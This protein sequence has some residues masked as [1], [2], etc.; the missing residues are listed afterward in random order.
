VFLKPTKLSSA[1]VFLSFWLFKVT[2]TISNALTKLSVHD[3][4]SHE[5]SLSTP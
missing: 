2:L 3:K 4:I 5:C 1:N